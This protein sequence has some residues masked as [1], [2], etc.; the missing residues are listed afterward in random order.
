MFSFNNIEH[1]PIK[2]N[3]RSLEFIQDNN[4]INL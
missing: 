4:Q 1:I 3:N 2:N